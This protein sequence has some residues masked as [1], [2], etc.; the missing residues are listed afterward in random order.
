MMTS[1]FIKGVIDGMGIARYAFAPPFE[2][3]EIPPEV[4]ESS[5]IPPQE[6]AKNIESYFRKAI[7]CADEEIANT[8]KTKAL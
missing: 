6:D 8:T 4:L 2:P 3:T 5:Y 7:A 1:D